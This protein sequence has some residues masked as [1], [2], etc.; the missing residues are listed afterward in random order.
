MA[1]TEV[2]LRPGTHPAALGAIALGAL[3]AAS[4]LAVRATHVWREGVVTIDGS[5]ELVIEAGASLCAAWVAL[6]AVVGLLYAV[7]RGAGR[8]WRSGR[9]FL[10]RCAPRLVRRMAGAVITAGVGVGIAAPGALAATTAGAG[11]DP[12]PPGVVL[13]L[14]WQP[15]TD[16]PATDHPATSRTATGGPAG[17]GTDPA[18]TDLSRP[19]QPAANTRHVGTRPLGSGRARDPERTRRVDRSAQDGGTRNGAAPVIVEVGDTLWWIA[20]AHLR[21]E[22]PASDSPDAARVAVEVAAWHTAN[23][24][25]IGPDPDLIQPGTVLHAPDPRS[26]GARS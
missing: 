26:L 25:T 20:A 19:G 8:D 24:K 13:D 12:A 4:T 22:S 2:D 11:P 7:S 23:R 1:L 17:S 18:A 10:S 21:S 15:T 14:G 6:A 9:A 16:H 3:T 5:L